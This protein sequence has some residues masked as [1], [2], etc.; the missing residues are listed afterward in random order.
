LER[1][2]SVTTPEECRAVWRAQMP[3]FANDPAKVEPMDDRVVFQPEA[4]RER[5]WGELHALD[6]LA[7][8]D[9]PCWR[10]RAPTTA[11]GRRRS[12]SGSVAPR[13]AASCS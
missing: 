13:R 12:P 6:A 7:A 3:F 11:R 2:G 1:E 9:A 8:L 10:S 4:H 5:D